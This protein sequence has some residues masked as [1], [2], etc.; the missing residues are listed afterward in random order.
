[1]FRPRAVV[2]IAVSYAVL[3][4]PVAGSTTPA[5]VTITAASRVH[6]GS[7]TASAGSTGS[8]RRERQRTTQGRAQPVPFNRDRGGKRGDGRGAVRSVSE[9]VGSLIV[10][11]RLIASW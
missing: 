10:S 3:V 2:A 1:M 8:W 6:V 9:P 11:E 5:L 7:A 4:M